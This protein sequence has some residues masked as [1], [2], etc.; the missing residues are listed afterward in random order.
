MVAENLFCGAAFGKLKIKDLF[1]GV[2][3]SGTTAKTTRF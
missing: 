1:E 2:V 3:P